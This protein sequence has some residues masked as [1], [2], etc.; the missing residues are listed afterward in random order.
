M[1]MTYICYHFQPS[2]CIKCPTPIHRQSQLHV[3]KAS[4][5]LNSIFKRI[6]VKNDK[7]FNLR[8]R[9]FF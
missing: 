6:Q 8:G 3:K 1:L 5:E 9:V 2:G 4:T 7:L